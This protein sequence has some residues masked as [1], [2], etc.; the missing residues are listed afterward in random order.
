MKLKYIHID[1]YKII[2]DE[3]IN[4]IPKEGYPKYYYDYFRNNFTILVGENGQGKT[5]L[6]SFITTIFHNIERYHD[7]I[8]GD[9]TMH[10]EIQLNGEEKQV[11]LEKEKDAIYITVKDTIA[12]SLLLE[13]NPNRRTGLND[14]R[15]PYPLQVTYKEIKRFLPTKTI[16]SVFSLHAEYPNSRTIRYIGEQRV[17]IFDIAKLYGANHYNFNSLSKGISRFVQMYEENRES[18]NNFFELLNLKFENKVRIFE[19]NYGDI[20]SEF[21]YLDEEGWIAITDD[22]KYK[23]LNMESNRDIYLNDLGFSK[24]GIDVN[25]SNMSSGEKMFIIRILSILSEI[26]DN[27]IIVIE[28]PELH[29][30]PSWTKQI[31]TMLHHFFKDYNVHFLISTHNYS[32]INTV[33]PENIIKVKYGEFQSWDSKKKTFL[34]NEAEIHNMFF[35]NIRSNNYVEEVLR[36]KIKEGNKQELKEIFDYLGESYNKFRLFNEMMRK[37]Y[38]ESDE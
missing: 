24:N 14:P 2:K 21:D 7:R 6:L 5:T 18:V 11:T 15:N 3:T 20:A 9:F 29:L 8:Y 13:N 22:N 1:N 12:R 38:V 33:F 32:F 36:K 16:A 26:E 35:E 23:V 17:K 10:Y 31:I 25:L 28:E 30:N 37:N 34:A 4:F 27:S 19:L